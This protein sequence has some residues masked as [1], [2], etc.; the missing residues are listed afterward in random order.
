MNEVEITE[1]LILAAEIEGAAA[2][3]NVGPGRGPG[4][5][6]AMALPYVHDWAD[7]NGWGKER[8]KQD[9]RE[10]QES[11]FRRPTPAQISEA[12]EAVGWY[13]LVEN[14]DH[15]R[16]LAVWVDCMVDN[17][18]RFFKDWCQCE[19]ISE[20]TGRKRKDAAIARI[21]AQLV[22][23]DVQN[24]NNAPEEGLFGTPEMD[25]VDGRIGDAWRGDPYS[26][27][28]SS[29]ALD[30]SWA[31]KRNERRRKQREAAKRKKEAA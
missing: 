19:K 2:F 15:R 7:K 18:R 3:A 26:L 13:A 6:R 4:Y 23:S 29:G 8:L 5:V 27:K 16:A 11:V 17:K 24:C 20:K 10:F 1:R 30:F 14:E 31:Q 9:E 22:R 28:H 25:D 12:E 21:L